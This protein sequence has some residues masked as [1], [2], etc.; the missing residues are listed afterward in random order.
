MPFDAITSTSTPA[1]LVHLNV[2]LL[3]TVRNYQQAK[4]AKTQAAAAAEAADRTY[5]AHKAELL[6]AMADAPAAVCG[7]M[8]LTKHQRSGAGASIT[9]K[10]GQKIAWADVGLVMLGDTS[11]I[12]PADITTIFGGR[13][14][15]VEIEVIGG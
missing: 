8:V 5:K 12:E 15:S 7:N 10:S 3:D 9:L 13:T 14:G 4:A 11:V 1:A 2:A 6:K